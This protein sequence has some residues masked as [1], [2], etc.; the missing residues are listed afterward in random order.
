[1]Q[2]TITRI[3]RIMYGPTASNVPLV[4]LAQRTLEVESRLGSLI[5]ETA[6]PS[7]NASA[8]SGETQA[9]GW[10]IQVTLYIPLLEA[11]VSNRPTSPH[12]LANRESTSMLEITE[13]L[14][15]FLSG[16]EINTA[17]D[18]AV[19]VIRMS[20]Q[21]L[22]ALMESTKARYGAGSI[23]ALD[24]DFSN[25]GSETKN[26]LLLLAAACYDPLLCRYVHKARF[27]I[28]LSQAIKL[29]SPTSNTCLLGRDILERI[30]QDLLAPEI[31]ISAAIA[32]S[33]RPEIS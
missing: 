22:L 4:D 2:Q 27:E 8:H 7:G 30:R 13:K 9:E 19:E 26:N 15:V 11:M 18:L 3:C 5:L 21:G 1:M 17:Q 29:H 20:K 33:A 24:T 12:R 25:T 23:D 31:E 6:D 28:L 14:A 16:G 32:L 10:G